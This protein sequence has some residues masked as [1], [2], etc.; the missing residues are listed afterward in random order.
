MGNEIRSGRFF[1]DMKSQKRRAE[2]LL[3][4]VGLDID[5]QTLMKDLNIATRQM[6]EIAKSL[7]INAKLIIMD[8]PTS[9]LTD[10]ETEKLFQIVRGVCA[11]GLGV[12]YISHRLEEVFDLARRVTVLRDG[13]TVGTKNLSECDRDDLISM[14]VGRSI[15]NLY[16]KTANSFGAEALRVEHISTSALL[17]DIS[18][19]VHSGEVL[20]FSGLVGAGRTELA[21]VIFGLDK[22]SGGDIFLA[23]KKATIGSS[24][25]AIRRGI[26]YVPED[27]KREGLILGMAV[28]DNISLSVLRRLKMFLLIN[29]G[30][31]NRLA[32]E[33]IVTV[34]YS[35]SVL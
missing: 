29:N 25:D 23:G 34:N 18:F 14:M 35:P 33:S 7:S 10:R 24:W 13:K 2:E 28:K 15:D 19:T 9:S 12:I 27:R 21:K 8:E 17:R 6:V 4:S 30:K 3:A 5:P 16:P 22:K 20:G 32:D 1:I 31:E 11:K 26:G